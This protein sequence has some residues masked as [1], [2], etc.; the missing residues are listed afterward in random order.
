[1]ARWHE[2]GVRQE[3]ERNVLR[4]LI[5]NELN[6]LASFSSYSPSVYPALTNNVG[7]LVHVPK[8]TEI[9]W[10]GRNAAP[11][12]RRKKESAGNV[13]SWIYHNLS[14]WTMITIDT[15]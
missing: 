4:Y 6:L 8:V 12:Q 9:C 10:L 11:C 5:G 14:L 7:Y 15:P 1:V 3:S 13:Y 2:K